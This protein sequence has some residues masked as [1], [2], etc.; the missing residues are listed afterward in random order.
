MT[1]RKLLLP[2]MIASATCNSVHVSAEDDTGFVLE[3]IVVTAQ[4]REQSLQDV[5]IS[6][7]AFDQNFI[8]DT[9]IKNINDVVAYTPGLSG[10]DEGL[11]T[12]QYAIRGISSNSFGIGGEASIGVFVDDAYTGR[13]TVAGLPFIDAAQIEVLKGPQGTLFGRNTSAGAISV[14][15]NRPHNEYALD[16]SQQFG[17]YGLNR[18]TVTA[19]IPIVEDVLAI[20]ASAVYDENDGYVENTTLDG[21]KFDNRAHAAKIAINYTPIDELDILFSYTTQDAKTGG[22]AYESQDPNS[23]YAQLSGLT[24]S[25]NDIFDDDVYH[26]QNSFEKTLAESANLRVLWDINDQLTL[27]SITTYQEYVNEAWL[28]LDSSPANFLSVDLRDGMDENGETF[29]QEFR[30]NGQV[31]DV[32]WMIG[33]SYFGE[34]VSQD[35]TLHMDENIWDILLFSDLATS[36]IL[37]LEPILPDSSNL[38]TANLFPNCASNDGA[39]NCGTASELTTSARGDYESQAIYTD[40]TWAASDNLNINAGLRYSRDKKDWSFKSGVTAGNDLVQNFIDTTLAA[41][42]GS[43]DLDALVFEGK[44]TLSSDDT[45]HQRLPQD[46]SWTKVTPRLAI[47]YTFDNDVMVYASAARGYKSG[48]F[49]NN[50]AFDEE[51][52]WSYELGFKSTLWESRMRLNGSIYYYD[53]ENFQ[54][55]VLKDAKTDTINIPEMKGK[56]AELEMAVRPLENLDV[57]ATLAYNESQI[58]DFAADGGNLKGNLPPYSPEKS[59]SLIG[60]Y[61]IDVFDSIQLLIQGEANYQSRQFFTLDNADSRS[62]AGYSLLN[63][64]VALF[65]EVSGWEVALFGSNLLDKEYLITSDDA[66]LS[67]QNLV[68]RGNPRMA[69]VELSLHF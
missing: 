18:T 38:A 37:G 31:G 36:G 57:I 67:G 55:Q 61:T 33:A 48:G 12:P 11:S 2:A 21:E 64:R 65:D 59:A 50:T 47:D 63:A 54:V 28:D 17:S 62:Q 66:F 24:P 41:S 45:Q 44:R 68:L 19:N 8:K 46:A 56:G 34:K 6:V 22:R 5:P 10:T 32:T 49:E 26:D 51:E 52:S 23:L 7:S 25:D 13:I 16:V 43:I 9:G 15:S 3:E 29:G 40:I 69:G 53:Y 1:F 58:G 39:V 20:R 35:V 42:G 27:T 30:L 60:R 14:T 4:R